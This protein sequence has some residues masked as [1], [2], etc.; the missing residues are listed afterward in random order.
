MRRTSVDLARTFES[1]ICS[2]K[3]LFLIET[4]QSSHQQS[5]DKTH[6]RPS[7]LHSFFLSHSLQPL[8]RS[9]PASDR[10]SVV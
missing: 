5:L 10:K 2:A 4:G 6:L 3:L 9:R 8:P 7:T 1:R